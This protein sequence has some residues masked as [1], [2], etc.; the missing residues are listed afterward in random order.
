MPRKP[1]KPC[2]KLEVRVMYEPHRLHDELLR[3]AYATLLP[4]A[5]RRIVSRKLPTA[6]RE[7]P[8]LEHAEKK[9]I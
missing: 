7:A 5:R 2:R 8:R 3:A 1:G 4:E 6:P 9:I